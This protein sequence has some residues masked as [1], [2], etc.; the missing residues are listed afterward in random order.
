[1]S[2]LP[3]RFIR[4]EEMNPFSR[5]YR[6]LIAERITPMTIVIVRDSE[7]LCD[8]RRS[9]SKFHERVFDKAVLKSRQP[10]SKY[11]AAKE[12]TLHT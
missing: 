7:L 6:P 11:S 9:I 10:M 12:W 2:I 5:D 8:P 3:L 1:M 4:A